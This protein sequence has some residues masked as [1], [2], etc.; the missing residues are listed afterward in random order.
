[1]AEALALALL[2][3]VL[4]GDPEGNP[5][6]PTRLVGRLAVRL[7]GPCRQLPLPQ[8]LQG[9]L[10]LLLVLAAVLIPVG[11]IT[12]TASLFPGGWILDALLLYFALGGGC[13][14]REIQKVGALLLRGDLSGARSAVALLVSRDTANLDETGIATAGVETLAENFG[15]AVCATLF[16]AVLGGPVLVWLHRTANTLDAMVGYKN[17]RYRRFGTLPALFDDLLNFVPARLAALTF[18]AA[19]PI[20]GGRFG[21]T[22]RAARYDGPGHES[23]NAGWPIAAAAGALGL[24]L[25]GPTVYDGILKGKPFF[26]AGS[27]PMGR[28]LQRSLTLFWA[29]YALAG[30]AFVALTGILWS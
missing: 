2:L 29:A 4:I 11:L 17:D 6:H 18:A 30:L 20:L 14:G 21:T 3:D 28:D 5:W 9:T 26:G 13:L 8:L 27:R 1:M 22:L 12:W 19:A 23:P 16:Y 25:G 24:R 15:D 7:E 10:F